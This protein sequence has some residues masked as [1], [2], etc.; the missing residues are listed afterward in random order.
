MP[1]IV[2]GADTPIGLAIA[3]ELLARRGEVRA[4]VSD[5]AVGRTLKERGAKVAIGDLSDASHV[6]AAALNAFSAVLV[7][8]AAMDERERNFAT[9]PGEVFAAW[10]EG[11]AASGVRRAIWVGEADQLEATAA[12]EA[13]PESVVVDVRGRPAGD[14]AADV[15]DLDASATL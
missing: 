2:I 11:L 10:A 5:D 15:A 14:V 9:T 12:M 4:F 8:C 1:V 13:A 6:G 7:T 3:N